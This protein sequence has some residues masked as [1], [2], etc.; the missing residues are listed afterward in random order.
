[1]QPPHYLE[2]GEHVQTQGKQLPAR[3]W[4]G[5]RSRGLCG[6]RIG[7]MSAMC[8]GCYR[9]G[10]LSE[11]VTHTGSSWMGSGSHVKKVV[12]IS[13]LGRGRSAPQPGLG[14]R[15]WKSLRSTCSLPSAGNLNSTTHKLFDGDAGKAGGAPAS[16]SPPFSGG[17]LHGGDASML[18]V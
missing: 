12:L 10:V 13:G 11:R 6:P 3:C 15:S 17:F 18:W 7:H 4:V 14:P 8:N 1:M 5:E 9:N 2:K 16:G